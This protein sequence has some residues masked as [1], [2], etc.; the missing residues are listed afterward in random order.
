VFP[1]NVSTVA[2]EVRNQSGAAV[3]GGHRGAR[4]YPAGRPV[5]IDLAH[6]GPPVHLKSTDGTRDA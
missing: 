6:Q 2:V 3:W 4:G 5:T 1:V